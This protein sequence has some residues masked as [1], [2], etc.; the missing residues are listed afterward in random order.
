MSASRYASFAVLL[1]SS[2]PAFA[3]GYS[4]PDSGIVAYGRGGAFVASADNQYAQYYNP[5]GLVRMERPTLNVG[6]SAVQ[7]NVTFTRLDEEGRF[8]DP[9]VNLAKPFL[10]P[11]LGFATPLTEDFGFAFG[12]YSPF[13]PDYLY[14]EDGAQ[15]YTIIDSVIWNFS[16]GPSLAW[17]PVPE[18]SV[19][20]GL[21]WQV[22][23][24][25]ERLKVTT[26]GRDDPNGDV[27]VDA[28]TLD[29]FTPGFNVGV[30]IEPV[31]ALSIG[32]SLQPATKFKARGNGELDFSESALAPFLDQT[33]YTD[34]DIALNIAL[35]LVL[36][37]GV[38]VRP[39]PTLE[40]EVAGYWEQWSVMSDITV[41]E[42]D[43]TVTGP[44]IGEQPVDET[45]ELP[46]G[47]RDVFSIR[48]GGEYQ[49][50]DIFAVRAGGFYETS[51]LETNKVSVALFDT[52]K[53]QLGTGTSLL[54]FD[55][56]GLDVSFAYLLFQSREVRNS[57]VTQINVLE[58]E[59]SVVG[60]G[61]YTSNGWM[62]GAG[63]TWAF[64][65]LPE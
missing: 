14:A 38:A 60:N 39:V 1:V 49:V 13:A 58:G 45:L 28:R 15:R 46:A 18:F 64:G 47:F 22:L 51:S 42:I 31:E 27:A 44:I 41:E 11:Q 35:P 61:D 26:S 50:T 16:I 34:D 48:L 4:F 56:L 10:I 21:Q 54:L 24:V 62:V 5:A 30:L 2:T 33:V 23:R 3:G 40:V 8:L 59:E 12:F 32:I 19:G 9:A 6:L 65:A 63:L 7:Q 55:H 25:E 37:G 36:R 29:V 52:P 20:F 57:E 43:V 53:I 17:Q